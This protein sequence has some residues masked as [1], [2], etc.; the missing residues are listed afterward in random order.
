MATI[1]SLYGWGRNSVVVTP[2][3]ADELAPQTRGFMVATAGDVALEW[4]G[5]N[6]VVIPGCQVGVQYAFMGFNKVLDTGTTPTSVL[7]GY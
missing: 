3:D 2:S 5:G 6:Q 1:N 7:V 4:P